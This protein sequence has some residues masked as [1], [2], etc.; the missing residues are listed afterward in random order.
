[1]CKWEGSRGFFIR[2]RGARAG[3]L[4]HWALRRQKFLRTATL[5]RLSGLALIV[6]ISLLVPW[7]TAAAATAAEYGTVTSQGATGAQGVQRLGTATGNHLGKATKHQKPPKIKKN[8]K[9]KG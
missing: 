5:R 3:S 9:V 7:Q 2:T 8:K 4:G 1:M 6:I